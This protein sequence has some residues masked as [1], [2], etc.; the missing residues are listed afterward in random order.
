M[1]LHLS[2]EAPATAEG[3]QPPL[4]EER[5][6]LLPRQTPTGQRDTAMAIP[7]QQ[8]CLLGLCVQER[9]KHGGE[10]ETHCSLSQTTLIPTAA[11][12]VRGRE[13]CF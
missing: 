11:V 10:K 4:D 8:V 13:L 5:T 7:T 1:S 9:P 2:E 6:Q 3:I 12:R